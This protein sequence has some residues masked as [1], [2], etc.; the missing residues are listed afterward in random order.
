MSRKVEFD[1]AINEEL[2]NLPLADPEVK[3]KYDL[4]AD[5]RKELQD[6]K[7]HVA[8]LE[9]NLRQAVEE[10]NFALGVALRKRLP[11]ITV[12]YD[13]GRCTANYR[14]TVLSCWPNMDMGLWSFEP[15]KHGRHFTR[16]NGH[17]LRLGNQIDPIV[18][19]IVGYLTQKY[20][21]LE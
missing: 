16:H 2:E 13:K 6:A 1:K 15:N 14:S 10:Y 3:G 5:I 7:A 8:E 11:Q 21:T 17:A 12:S 18:D 20:R 19:A 4:I 9:M